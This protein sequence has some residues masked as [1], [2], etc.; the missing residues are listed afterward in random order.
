[1]E[2]ILLAVVVALVVLLVVAPPR[3]PQPPAVLISTNKLGHQ[4]WQF[5]L[6][7]SAKE[8][9]LHLNSRWEFQ[10]SLRVEIN[11]TIEQI[12]PRPS[13]SFKIQF[14]PPTGLPTVAT[15][16]ASP[17]QQQQQQPRTVDDNFSNN[18]DNPKLKTRLE[19]GCP[20]T[21][22]GAPPPASISR[23]KG[24]S[25]RRPGATSGGLEIRDPAADKED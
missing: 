8:R 7:Q 15:C 24:A 10:A 20:L 23:I 19:L 22:S 2:I 25:W 6:E 11:S 21:G 17:V 4:F 3:P 12:A 16:A 14:Q 5:N 13:D 18:N 9:K 1:M